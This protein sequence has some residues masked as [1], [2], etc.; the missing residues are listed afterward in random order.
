MFRI[1]VSTVKKSNYGLMLLLLDPLVRWFLSAF[2]AADVLT[3]QTVLS[4]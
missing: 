2:Y 3:D 1:L 4:Y